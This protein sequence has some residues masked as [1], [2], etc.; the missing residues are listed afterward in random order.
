MPMMTQNLNVKTSRDEDKLATKV[1]AAAMYDETELRRLLETSEVKTLL[2]KG[3]LAYRRGAM[4][5]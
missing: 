5:D 3:I 1:I 2:E 4:Y